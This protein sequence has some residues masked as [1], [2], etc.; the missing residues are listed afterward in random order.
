MSLGTKATKRLRTAAFAAAAIGLLLASLYMSHREPPLVRIGEIKPV[1]NFS[2]VRVQGVLESEARTLRDGA[3]LYL[4]ADETGSLPIF[5]HAPVEEL[6]KA[7]NWVVA[8]GCL[9]V[10][11]G[12]QV[13]MQ[14]HDAGQIEVIGKPAPITVHGQVSDVWTP[15]PDSR[16]P[17][18]IVLARPEGSLEVVHWFT[19]K[20]QVVVD[21]RLEAKGI[22][23]SYKGRLQL[24]VRKAEDIRLQPEG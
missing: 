9:S 23:G 16:A 12:S 6:P 15:P 2:T 24:K 18:R 14:V 17:Y 5:S 7:G 21:D 4:I 10:G 22:L 3:V 11:A 19:P 1:M 20:L 8:T 13:R